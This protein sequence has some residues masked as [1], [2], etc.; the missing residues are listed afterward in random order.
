MLKFFQRRYVVHISYDNHF[1]KLVKKQEKLE[2]LIND[3]NNKI[4]N[5]LI[6]NRNNIQNNYYRTN[7]TYYEPL[8]QP[9]IFE[10]EEPEECELTDDVKYLLEKVEYLEEKNYML[11]NKME[12][13]EKLIEKILNQMK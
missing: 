13:W 12:L 3:Q 11:T 1:N 10:E 9:Q 6:N 2:K 4:S 5:I 8:F 7:D